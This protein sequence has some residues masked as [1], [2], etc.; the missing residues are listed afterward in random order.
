M[1]KA[2]ALIWGAG[3]LVCLAVILFRLQGGF[4]V[5]T[6][7]LALLP[8]EEQSPWM[9]LANAR[10][11]DEVVN[12][13]VILLR[14]EDFDSLKTVAEDL[15]ERL[16]PVARLQDFEDQ[17]TQ[18]AEKL[19]DYRAALLSPQDRQWLQDGRADKVSQRALA[20]I[21]A[22]LGFTN[23]DMIRNDPYLLFPAYLNDRLTNQS[24]TKMKDGWL[25]VGED[26]LLLVYQLKGSPFS[27]EV[28]ENI[29][30]VLDG[31]VAPNGVTLY[32]TGAVFYAQQGIE[33]GMEE[34]SLIGGLS[35]IGII[36]LNLLVFRSVQPLL[37]SLLAITSGVVVGAGVC[38]IF[39]E[40]LHMMAFVFGAGLIGISVD[41][42][43]H[44]C[45]ACTGQDGATNRMKI[46]EIIR[47]LSFG[48][49]SSSLGFLI[50]AMTPFPG[51]RQIAIF[52]C[53]GLIA[54]YLCVICIYPLIDRG[55]GL[56][57]VWGW[58]TLDR[59]WSF[60]IGGCTVLLALAG[61]AKFHVDDDVRRL[62]HLP[63]DLS[64]EESYI[65]KV[66]QL[67]NNTRFLVV[68]GQSVDDVLGMQEKLIP[69]LDKAQREGHLS[70]YQSVAQFVPSRT[71]QLENHRLVSDNLL[72]PTLMQHL[73]TLGLSPDV[74]PYPLDKLLKPTGI[75]DE[76][77]L[78]ATV[79]LMRLDGVQLSL[80]VAD[81]L[82]GFDGVEQID[83]TAA[84]SRTF[85]TYR[86]RALWMIA[87]ACGVIWVFL[88][89]NY[90]V[91]RASCLLA[92]PVC[93]VVTTPF[94]AAL[95]GESFT[96]FNAMALLLVLA[97]GLDYALF[98]HEAKQDRF[99]QVMVA[100]AMSALSTMMAFGLLAFSDLY[101]IHAFG[102]TILIGIT[103]S[104]VLSSLLRP[105]EQESK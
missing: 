13:M 65:R 5:E 19:F 58:A 70:G 21:M 80:N 28:Q 74:Q 97:I 27:R 11:N 60:I 36:L 102:V 76:L 39:F 26:H 78:S 83:Q 8:D 57:S 85:G 77:Q 18:L 16:K 17:Y 47:P 84:I 43:F 14:G 99:S 95:F 29:K 73:Q 61:A 103:I 38:L 68:R 48:V 79:H 33:Q 41:Y 56:K 37:L 100:N 104:F 90:G 96:L 69:L 49:I 67:D 50:L 7:F 25:M 62:Q 1:K 87:L 12:R 55:T 15:S 51:L 71:R 86:A 75:L 81:L 24:A 59:N 72:G 66:T 6:N 98:S 101:A 10:I 92:V 2:G 35:L 4:P 30:G 31:F 23:A 91:K 89:K 52:A 44:Y 9:E 22:P 88:S 54:A 93:A 46:N 3:L 45:C 64:A 42:T 32:K 40:K 20:Q 63:A 94:I 53:S 105:Q 34:A 82:A